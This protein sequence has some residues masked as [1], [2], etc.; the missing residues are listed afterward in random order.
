MEKRIIQLN[1]KYESKAYLIDDEKII[2]KLDCKCEDF[3]YRRI[4]SVG[5]VFDTKTYEIP[6][7]HLKHLVDVLIKQGYVLKQPKPMKGTD[8]CT[9]AL[10]KLL[11]ERSNGL[12]EC[13]C[14]R[15]GTDVHRQIAGVNGGKYNK[16]NCVLLNNECHKNITFQPWHK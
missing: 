3:T 10:R 2:Y 14:G 16:D 15:I 11:I 9:V 13:G 8:K 5:V 1:N 7:K 6:C 4:K 12:C